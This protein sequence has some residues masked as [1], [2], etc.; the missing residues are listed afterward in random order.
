ME[1]DIGPLADISNTVFAL[2]QDNLPRDLTWP[3]LLL[4]AVLAIVIWSLRGGR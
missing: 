1:P 3:F 4:T 2:I